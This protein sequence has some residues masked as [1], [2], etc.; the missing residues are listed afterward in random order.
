MGPYTQP[1]QLHYRVQENRQENKQEN[2]DALSRLPAGEDVNFDREEQAADISTVCT[3]Q[4]ISRQ[5]NP[6]DTGTLAKQSKTDPIISTVMRYVKEGWPQVT[7][8]VRHYMKLANSLTMENGCLLL[9]S[10]IVIPHSLRDQVLQLIHLGHFGMQRM[11]QVA[12]SVV[13]WP[14]IN[15][16][17]EDLSRTCTVCGEHQNKPPKPANHP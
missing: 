4:T 8:D 13:Y 7:E 1:V 12:R 17:I 6:T 10:R 15:D 16:D 9:G 5:L 2:A 14:R 3:I 11:K